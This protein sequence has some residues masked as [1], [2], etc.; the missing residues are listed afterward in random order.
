MNTVKSLLTGAVCTALLGCGSGGNNENVS[1][2][3]V[4]APT[5]TAGFS[6]S[7]FWEV[8]VPSAGTDICYDFDTKTEDALCESKTWDLKL[9][10]SG[11][12]AS[13]A[14][15][16]GPSG[17]GEGG[18]F[19]GPF[20]RQWSELLT[21]ANAQTDPAGG[22]VPDQL[23]F[24]DSAK[25][26][27]T[28]ENSIQSAAFEYALTG[29]QDRQLYPTYRVFLI[30]SNA[31]SADASGSAGAPVFALQVTG[32]YGGETGAESGF[33]S[34]QWIDRA[35]PAALRQ[36]TV[37]ATDGSVY[38]DLATGAQTTEAGNW[39]V[40]FDRFNGK[41]NGGQSGQGSAAGYLSK[42]PQALY[43][44]AGEPVV[45]AF[46]S[47]TPA[48]MASELT[49]ELATPSSARMWV[50]DSVSS[51]LSPDYRGQ[52]PAALDFGFYKYYPSAETAAAAGLPATANSLS[53]NAEQG[54][55][56][57]S[58]EGNSFARMRLVEIQYADPN[59]SASQQTWTV[60]F[61]IQPA[62]SGQ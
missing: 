31:D 2:S 61:G 16:S 53:A 52:F 46:L 30:T 26:V 24:S 55:L 14:T 7:A 60:E 47:A 25:S 11:R 19:G 21:W 51:P 41:V 50:S 54:T 13:F 20:E 28:G 39:H 22:V 58:G 37:D 12:S 8:K 62:I 32:Y 38:F 34:F 5:P 56:L 36:A 49:D 42:T 33:V 43:N 40:A 10:S 15:N 57:R 59:D 6:D 48:L 29:G 35:A 27:F 18:A 1:A 44:S 45:S 23:Y 9:L 3:P 4:P 17:A